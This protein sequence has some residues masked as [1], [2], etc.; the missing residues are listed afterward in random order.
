MSFSADELRV[1]RRALAEALAHPPAA[2]PRPAAEYRRLSEVLE[3]AAREGARLRAFLL[4]ELVRYRDALPAAADGYLSR[5]SR[6][7]DDGYRPL[8]RDLAALR[9]LA[10]L[11]AGPAE[12]HRRTALLRRGEAAGA[13]VAGGEA[14]GGEAACGEAECRD[15]PLGCRGMREPGRGESPA[16]AESRARG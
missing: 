11:P 2:P 16:P 6:A 14:A 5:L 7:L 4:A 1:V 13:A 3:E 8:P 10:A 9:E 15:V 12:S